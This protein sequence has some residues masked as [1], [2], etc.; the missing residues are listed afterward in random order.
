MPRELC[1]RRKLRTEMNAG[2]RGPFSVTVGFLLAACTS[3]IPM[4]DVLPGP[5]FAPSP[6]ATATTDPVTPMP[7]PTRTPEP[8]EP[9]L[10]IGGMARV[11]TNIAAGL[12]RWTEPTDKSSN[13]RLNRLYGTLDEGALVLLVDGPRTVDGIDYWQLWPSYWQN[14]SPLGWAAEAQPDGDL[15]LYPY[16]PPC[17]PAEGLLAVH[18]AALGRLESLSCFGD[19]LL[20]LSGVVTCESGHGDGVLAGP[21]LSSRTWCWLD[22]YL[23]LAGPAVTGL[24]ADP[25]DTPYFSGT[26]RIRGRFDDPEARYCYGTPFGTNLE[27]RQD[28]GDPGAVMEC[29]MF[30]VVS[31]AEP[32]H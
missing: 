3:N 15:N 14:S 27:G 13:R 17:P 6:T 9:T 7:S 4:P 23:Q 29:R 22:N 31:D 1:W 26:Y 20:T 12:P 19:R 5:T 2:L 21:I 16:E 28:P 24:V 11:V 32:V 18:L 25:H 8:P 30:F 10:H